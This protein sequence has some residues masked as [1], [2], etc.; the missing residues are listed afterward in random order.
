MK[1][2]QVI[3]PE[4]QNVQIIEKLAVKATEHYQRAADEDGGVSA[5]RLWHWMADVDL[6]PFLALNIKAMQIVDVIMIAAAQ[7]VKLVVINS[8]C[9]TP[10]STGHHSARI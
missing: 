1:L 6:L 3:L 9:M 10:T 4:V 2:S 5:S 7:D 8:S